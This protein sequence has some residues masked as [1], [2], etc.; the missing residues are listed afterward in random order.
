MPTY[1]AIANTAS[2]FKVN[3]TSQLF[4]FTVN[5]LTW[6]HEVLA[7]KNGTIL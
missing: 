6:F 7:N 2:V 4:A 1:W 3:V 5:S